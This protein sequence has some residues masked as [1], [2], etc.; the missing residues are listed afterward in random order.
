MGNDDDGY[1]YNF[2]GIHDTEIFSIVIGVISVLF[3]L[4]VV[5][6]LLYRYT[7]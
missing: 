1:H 2:A 4:S 7:S 5:V 6:I 3:P